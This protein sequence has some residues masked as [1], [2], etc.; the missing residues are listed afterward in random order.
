MFGEVDFR[1]AYS[2]QVVQKQGFEWVNLVQSS[3]Q[4]VLLLPHF[5]TQLLALLVHAMQYIHLFKM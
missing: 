4:K 1:E 5:A 2:L 3:M